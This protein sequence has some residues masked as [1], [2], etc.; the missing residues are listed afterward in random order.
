[1]SRVAALEILWII[2]IAGPEGAE[3][4]R[5]KLGFEADRPQVAIDDL[6]DLRSF[7]AGIG[8]HR[9]ELYRTA[10]IVNLAQQAAGTLRIE[11][12][13]LQRRIKTERRLS[14]DR[15]GDGATRALR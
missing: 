2:G 10:V 14:P 11:C 1:M 13:R 12:V 3:F 8:R 7:R 4:Q 15:I 6:H 9:P 5:C